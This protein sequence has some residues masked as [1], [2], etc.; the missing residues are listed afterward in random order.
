[1]A[2]NHEMSLIKKRRD[3]CVCFVDIA[4]SVMKDVIEGDATIKLTPIVECKGKWPR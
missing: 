4:E 1:M 2:A 3:V